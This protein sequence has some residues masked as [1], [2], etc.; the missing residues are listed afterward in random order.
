MQSRILGMFVAF[1]GLALIPGG[2]ASAETGV[3]DDKILLGSSLPLSG[4]FQHDGEQRKNAMEAAIQAV[5]KA[6]GIHR[7]KIE[8]LYM[9]DKF[10]PSIASDNTNKFL[11]EKKVFALV[12][13]VGTSPAKVALNIVKE[14]GGLL[15]GSISGADELRTPVTKEVF[16]VRPS[17]KDE[18]ERI[19]SYLF[20]DL[21]LKSVA[22]IARKDYA[23]QSQRAPIFQSL[24]KRGVRPAAIIELENFEMLSV[25]KG[26]KKIKEVKPEAVVLM[27]NEVSTI[28][29]LK[30]AQEEGIK[31]LFIG[32]SQVDAASVLSAVGS[33][34][35]GLVTASGY[36][37][38]DAKLPIVE[39]FRAEM[40][41]AGF[42]GS[43]INS[44]SLE[45]Y[46]NLAIFLDAVTKT[47]VEL[48]REKVIKTLE[49]MSNETL[50]GLN[51]RL[52][53]ENHQALDKVY[54]RKIKEGKVI[55]I[56]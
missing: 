50:M 28:P 52:S 18:A 51:V 27:T 44:K 8:I 29:L 19:V 6:G 1:L 4:P 55:G 31:S 46:V 41:A 12:N 16:T 20:K 36:P 37:P 10:Q 35:E 2:S 40:K 39:K 45:A 17:G 33:A 47:G 9:D 7:R 56:D 48:T 53:A 26:I 15:F 34:A 11:D 43:E 24:N 14:K 54:L 22:V 32:T 42:S 5:N 21:S 13:Y 38:E 25:K 30:A 23:G 49:G 3:S